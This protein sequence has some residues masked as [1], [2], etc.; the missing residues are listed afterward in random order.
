LSTGATVLTIC[1]TGALATASCG[2]ALGIIRTAWEDGRLSRVYVCETRPLLQG[3]RLTLW[4][5]Q[6]LNIP[7]TLIVDSAAGLLLRRGSV[8]CVIVGADRVAANGDVANKVGTYTLAIL[9]H[10]HEVPFYVAA[11]TSSID[12]ATA[13]G[14]DIPIEERSAEEV[15]S[16]AGV[17]T[18]PEGTAALNPAFDV[19]PHQYIT[20]IITERGIAREPYGESLSALCGVA[21]R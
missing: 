13:S 19:T 14:D 10:Q 8:S 21:A 7:H 9:A 6:R 11:P 5:L 16:F 1:N 17:A 18:A 20:A 2:T 12:L 4:E 15:T 3:A